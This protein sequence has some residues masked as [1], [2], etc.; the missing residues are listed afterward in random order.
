MPGGLDFFK[1][2][3]APAAADE[4]ETETETAADGTGDTSSDKHM[5]VSE[6][7]SI[8]KLTCRMRMVGKNGYGPCFGLVIVGRVP[9][10]VPTRCFHRHS[11]MVTTLRR[12]P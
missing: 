9:P 12:V 2:R 8:D 5:A 1:N 4:E 6:G 3:K 7:Y 11:R 10:P